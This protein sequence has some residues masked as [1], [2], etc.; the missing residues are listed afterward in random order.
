MSTNQAITSQLKS[1]SIKKT[2]TYCIINKIKSKEYHTVGT[3]P[4]FYNN[5]GNGDEIHIP[6]NDKY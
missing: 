6:N 2:M 3:V 1:L 5:R 4:K